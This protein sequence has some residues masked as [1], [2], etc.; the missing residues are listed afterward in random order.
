M[1]KAASDE[2]DDLRRGGLLPGGLDGL[3]EQPV[4]ITQDACYVSRPPTRPI[5]PP[6]LTRRCPSGCP[7]PPR[8]PS[9]VPGD[10]AGR[11]PATLAGESVRPD[12]MMPAPAHDARTASAPQ[13]KLRH[14]DARGA[15]GC[16]LGAAPSLHAADSLQPCAAPRRFS[17]PF[18]A[19][20]RPQ[21]PRPT[22]GHTRCA[23]V[24]RRSAW[25][26]RVRDGCK[27]RG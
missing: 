19:Q 15:C 12:V 16:L 21:A 7:A 9:R 18:A 22:H 1:R 3:K 4:D 2:V 25:M 6:M 10:R 17:M 24:S 23:A 11:S 14:G 8:D 27:A 13:S 5:S 26:R 20:A